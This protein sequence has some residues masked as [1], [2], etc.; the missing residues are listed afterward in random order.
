M[1]R[2]QRMKDTMSRGTAQGAALRARAN[3]RRARREL[4]RAARYQADFP[5]SDVRELVA[6]ARRLATMYVRHARQNWRDYRFWRQMYR[7]SEAGD[8]ALVLSTCQPR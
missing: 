1:A 5:D 2:T 7:A 8:V 3:L 4:D 6:G